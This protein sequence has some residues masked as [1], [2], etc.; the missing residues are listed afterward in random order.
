M[1]SGT[2]SSMSRT[3][4]TSASQGTNGHHK[5]S[6][7]STSKTPNTFRSSLEQFRYSGNGGKR[8]VAASD[9]S[10]DLSEAESSAGEEPKPKKRRLVRGGG[11]RA[12]SP[13][14][15]DGERSSSVKP[16]A[17]DKDQP[18]TNGVRKSK[19]D[20][21]DD[22]VQEV[23]APP[24]KKPPTSASRPPTQSASSAS[25]APQQ[26]PPPISEE[27]LRQKAT[28]IMKLNPIFEIKRIL[29]ALR[30]TRGNVEKTMQLLNTRPS[31]VTT[32]T[33]SLKPSSNGTQ[34]PVQST[35]ANRPGLNSA[36]QASRQASISAPASRSSTP[37]LSRVS[38]QTSV[39]QAPPP[40]AVK[41]PVRETVEVSSDED[42]SD[43]HNRE[44]KEERAAVKWFNTADASALMDTTNCSAQQAETIMSLRPFD[45][46]EDIEEKLGSKSAKGVTPRLFHQC[47]DLMGVITK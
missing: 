41:K 16:K 7:S 6:S 32:K 15:S 42:D 12:R 11:A 39:S 13:D 21:D 2:G 5:S 4:F 31:A 36:S 43:G 40:P 23:P 14:S 30:Q 25:P 9:K 17:D 38:S 18:K 26:A 33:V 10:S 22:D 8:E 3:A 45:D 46:A 37:S 27:E 24:P 47:K 19:D 20:D 29:A 35:L 44:E 1:S 28:R 34:R